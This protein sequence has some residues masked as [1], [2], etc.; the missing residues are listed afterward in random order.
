M[1]VIHNQKNMKIKLLLTSLMIAVVIIFSSPGQLKAQNFGEIIQA[2]TADANQYVQNYTSPAILSF[3][4]GMANGWYN[5]AKPHKLIGIDLTF[6]LNI[7]GIPDGEELFTFV[8]SEYDNLEL[9]SGSSAQLPTMVGGETTEGLVIPVSTNINGFNVEDQI[10]IDAPDGFN[11]EDVPFAG[12]PAPTLQL[13]IGLPKNTDLK[14]RLVPEQNFDD[15]SFRLFG[16]GVMHDVKQWIPGMKLVPIDLSAFIGYTSLSSEIGIN[17]TDGD[18]QGSG[19]AEFSA[20]AT[21][22]QVVASK[23][24]VFFTPYVG[25]G[26]NAVSSNLDVLGDYTLSQ[27]TQSLD[28]TDPISLEY[29]EGGG[30]RA[31]IGGRLKLLVLTIHADYTIQK[32]STFTMGLGISVR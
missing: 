9:A 13:G 22:V 17:L 24:L 6:S 16:V 31:T 19:T 26:F 1:I 32:Y 14:I 27:G 23:N 12:V 5:T 2:G 4:N 30:A 10:N 11:L 29:S 8:N 25:L 3:A 28:F 21:T 20:S 15:V 18:F 7:A